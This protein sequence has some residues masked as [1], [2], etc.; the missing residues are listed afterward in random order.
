[1]DTLMVELNG[2]GVGS[3]L[4]EEVIG[5]AQRHYSIG[6]HKS[7]LFSKQKFCTLYRSIAE[8]R[9]R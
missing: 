3:D 8:S 9:E 1:M 6:C 4:E 5:S 2:G 7:K